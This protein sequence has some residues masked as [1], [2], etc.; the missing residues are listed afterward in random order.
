MTAPPADRDPA[1]AGP[2]GRAWA[3]TTLT[4]WSSLGARLLAFGVVLLLVLGRFAPAEVALWLLCATV[5]SFQMLFDFGFSPTFSRILAYA[6]GGASVAEL[7]DL[8]TVASTSRGPNRATLRAIVGTMR[9]VFFWTAAAFF[10][11]AAVLGTAAIARSAG[12]LADPADGWRAWAVVLVATTTLLWGSQYVAYLQGINE[13]ARLRRWETLFALGSLLTTSALLLG[14]DCSLFELALAQHVWTLLA[15]LRNRALCRHAGMPNDAGLGEPERAV[16]RS[17]WPNAWKSAIGILTGYGV[18]QLSGVAYAQ[19]AP[20]AAVASYLL[21]LRLV[22]T[23]SQFS[24]APFYSKLPL[25]ARLR[26]EGRVAD[27]IIVAR[28]GMRL[29][30]ATYAIGFVAVGA[31]APAL[32]GSVGSDTAFVD[33]GLWSALGFAFLFERLGAM[34]LQLY[35]TTNHIIW[36][37]AN[38]WTGVASVALAIAGFPLLGVLAFPLAMLVAHA[39]VYCTVSMRHSARAFALPLWRFE[40][41][42]SVPA[43]AALL[44]YFGIAGMRP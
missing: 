30:H 8:R 41:T 42:V 36:H 35:S 13:V 34:H 11:A 37:I 26:A 22:Q 38:G 2:L 43:F 21:A 27:Q 7:A 15:V 14:H 44:L 12:Q 39:A 9:P 18:V 16:L 31:F 32:L 4:T 5:A 28:R 17:A 10:A 6:M 3:S 19:F 40:A 25:L 24:Q 29:A 20:P 33:G 1:G 23:V